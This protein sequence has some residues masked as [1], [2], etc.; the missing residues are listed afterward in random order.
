L[1]PDRF[2]PS[3]GRWTRW[4]GPALLG[5]GAAAAAALALQPTDGQGLLGWWIL[6]SALAPERVLP[7]VGL[8]VACSLARPQHA[9]AA[10]VLFAAGIAVGF[11]A[12]E[13][14][15][16]VLATIPDAAAHQFRVTPLACIAAGLALAPGPRLRPWLLPFAAA[17]VGIALALAIFLTDPSFHDA[18]IPGAGILVGA[19]ITL[20]VWLTGRAFSRRW[21]GIA[22]RILGSWLIAIGLLYGAAWLAPRA[23]PPLPPPAAAG[24][25]PSRPFQGEGFPDFGQPET[26][27]GPPAPSAMP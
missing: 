14:A 16:L 15:L 10:L 3:A 5:L 23:E 17:V 12:R 2:H 11:L 1:L 25:A 21:F 22:G 26:L 7:L 19:W 18:T 20:A 4:T 13:Q 9:A 24:D 27:P 8:G 6:S